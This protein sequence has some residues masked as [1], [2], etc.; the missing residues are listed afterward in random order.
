MLLDVKYRRYI[1]FSFF[2]RRET[3]RT[4]TLWHVLNCQL[5]SMKIC[6]PSLY[7]VIAGL[8]LIVNLIYISYLNHAHLI[9]SNV[10][11]TS[12]EPVKSYAINLAA[13]HSNSFFA[14]ISTNAVPGTP[15]LFTKKTHY[16]C[17][18]KDQELRFCRIRSLLR[19]DR[20]AQ[21]Y[22]LDQAKKPHYISAC[23]AVKLGGDLIHEFIISNY[24]AGIDH[25]Y[26][27]D[28]NDDGDEEDL[29]ALLR[30][31]GPLVTVRKAVEQAEFKELL[32][33]DKSE[34]LRSFK[35]RQHWMYLHCF[36]VYGNTTTWLM[37]I[38]L[39]E[40]LEAKR[41]EQHDIDPVVFEDVPFMQ[42]YLRR[43]EHKTPVQLG[44]WNTVLTNNLTLPPQPATNP[45]SKRYPHTCGVRDIF[46]EPN[47]MGYIYCVKSAIQ[48]K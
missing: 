23:V 38:D 24:L 21:K 46:A 36:K 35:H 9:V 34:R 32:H 43:I 17:A 4:L 20:S 13:N 40:I 28:D 39:D 5:S 48:P 25:Y 7:V 41:P 30:P 22:F 15:P 47:D 11:T 33:W 44:R 8:I 42:M 2:L 3:Q 1:V 12:F 18:G 45:L 26:V 29:E 10:L 19:G 31:F 37:P 14:Q 6:C 27:Y 16:D